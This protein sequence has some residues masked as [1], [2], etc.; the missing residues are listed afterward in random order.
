MERNKNKGC[1]PG[2]K[3]FLA[4]A[5]MIQLYFPGNLNA[6][7]GPKVTP[8][9]VQM[10]SVTL[11][12]G[13]ATVKLNEQVLEEL[14]K[15]VSDNDYYVFLTPIGS[16]NIPLTLVEKGHSAFTVETPLRN[17]DVTEIVKIDYIIYVNRE[18]VSDPDL[19]RKSA[20]WK[21]E[22]QFAPF[23]KAGIGH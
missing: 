9:A 11:N 20:T 3:V 10:G 21:A 17:N 13:K 18:V 8:T 5:V 23:V 2:G 16:G 22:D 4:I 14:K 15:Q 6:Q 19:P 1:F 7:T 12:H